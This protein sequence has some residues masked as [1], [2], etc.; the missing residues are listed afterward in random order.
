LRISNLLGIGSV[1]LGRAHVVAVNV[2]L[3]VE[4]VPRAL[5]GGTGLAS[6]DLALRRLL[7]GL[8]AG[9]DRE[10]EHDQGNQGDACDN[11]RDECRESEHQLF[12]SELRARRAATLAR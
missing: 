4:R 9:A 1:E 8:D 10:A 12:P 7:A 2:G 3:G 11:P 6:I 5:A